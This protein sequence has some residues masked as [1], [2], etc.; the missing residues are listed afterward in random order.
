MIAPRVH[1]LLCLT[2]ALAP[3]RNTVDAQE[4]RGGRNPL[5]DGSQEGRKGRDPLHTGDQED[6]K[7][8]DPVHSLVLSQP[9]Q[10]PKL[11]LTGVSRTD[12]GYIAF[13]KDV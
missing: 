12:D 7:G 2:I 9:L 13:L 10:W 8:R 5:H 11:Q 4:N 1:L 6:R 3:L